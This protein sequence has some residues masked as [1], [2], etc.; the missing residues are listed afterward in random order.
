MLF[1]GFSSQEERR[2][3][4]G[5]CFAELAFCKGVGDTLFKT[6][7]LPFWKNDSLY[8]P[9]MEQGPFWLAYKDIVGE[10]WY[11]PERRGPL[12]IYGMNYYTPEDLEAI[13][14]RVRDQQPQDWEKLLP[15]LEEARKY[16]GFY[17]LGV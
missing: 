8:I 13:I 16:N 9:D 1:Y 2:T 14:T 15:W 3:F 10:G 11:S 7:N 4:G 6:E 12:D 17:I 5:S